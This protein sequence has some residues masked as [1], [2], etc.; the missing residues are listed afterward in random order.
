MDGWMDGW[1]DGWVE[2]W[3]NLFLYFVCFLNFLTQ[4]PFPLPN[5][6][7]TSFC[8]ITSPPEYI[9]SVVLQIRCSSP[10]Q[11]RSKQT[12]PAWL[13]ILPPKDS[14]SLID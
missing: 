7:L 14:E 12:T 11:T 13:V 10:S 3:F 1:V 5:I 4:H 8:G 6:A 9:V 2:Y